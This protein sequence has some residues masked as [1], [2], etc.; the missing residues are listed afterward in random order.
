[1]SNTLGLDEKPTEEQ[2][3]ELDANY[4]ELAAQ[5]A[6]GASWFYWIAGLSAI[7]SLVYLSGSDW[8]FLAGL[9]LT[10]LADGFVDAAIE[11]G[12]PA[13][14]KGVAVVFNFALVAM[15]GFFGYYAGK[16]FSAAFL[17]GIVIYVLDGLLLL[18]LGAWPSA[19]FHAFAL[20]FI[21]RGFLACRKLNTYDGGRA[22]QAPPPP[23]VAT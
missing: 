19:G 14:V 7:N 13:A 22:F 18:L 4:N 15:F 1:M 9:G 16:R 8:S 17:V 2:G 23:P 3:Q 12:V 5:T 10:Q 11:N 21:I 20:F 6:N